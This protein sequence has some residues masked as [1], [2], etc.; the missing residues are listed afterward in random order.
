MAGRGRGGFEG[1]GWGRDG[2]RG[3][4]F[5][6]PPAHLQQQQ[7]P[8]EKRPA[9]AAADGEHDD[10]AKRARLGGSADGGDTEGSLAMLQGYGDDGS[11]D[12]GGGA[13]VDAAQAADQAGDGG[14]GDAGQSAGAVAR[15]ACSM[16]KRCRAAQVLHGVCTG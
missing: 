9:D 15:T 13:G 7:Q 16:C 1:R 11:G 3:R 2:G 12:E 5:S 6:H 8:G 14:Y 10:A 4:G